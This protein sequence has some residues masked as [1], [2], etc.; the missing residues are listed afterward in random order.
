[1]PANRQS[2]KTTLE[3]LSVLAASILIIIGTSIDASAVAPFLGTN[4]FTI[5]QSPV[6]CTPLCPS[7]MPFIKVVYK[8][9]LNSTLTA[10][11][12]A[13]VYNSIGQTVGVYLS[14]ISAGGGENVTT[15]V[16]VYGFGV[17][18]FS[19]TV[20][21]ATPQRVVI[22]GNARVNFTVPP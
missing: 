14:T 6:F 11:V 13:N 18:N 12:Y 2:T 5:V 15:N 9:N 3:F 22:S 4:T 10:L 1:M 8:N 16:A 20:F 7:G 17:G 21:A 19:A